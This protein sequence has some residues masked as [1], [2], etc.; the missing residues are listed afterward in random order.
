MSET[1]LTVDQI[2]KGPAKDIQAY[3][4]LLY[5]GKKQEK[6]KMEKEIAKNKRRR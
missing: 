5:E 1:T 6:E 3:L 4:Y 2:R